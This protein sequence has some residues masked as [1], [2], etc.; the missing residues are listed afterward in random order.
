[1]SEVRGGRVDM[2]IHTGD[3]FDTAHPGAHAEAA[4]A[5]LAEAASLVPTVV[6][7]GNHDKRGLAPIL[8]AHPALV[9]V[10]HPRRM[11][12]GGLEL[13]CIPYQRFSETFATAARALEITTAD[14]VL[15][16]QTFHGHAVPGFMFRVG[17]HRDVVGPQHL[18]DREFV[19]LCGHIHTRQVVRTAG[20]TVVTPG[21]TE[22][23]A[24]AEASETKG[25]AL[26]E[27]GRGVQWRFVDT[28]TRPMVVAR[29]P[30]DL[31]RVEPG[32]LVRAEADLH[33]DV[34]QRG[35]WIA[36][37]KVGRPLPPGPRPRQLGLL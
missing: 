4:A 5:L 36:P 23:T 31:D 1:M 28:P 8:G 25:Y 11:R 10:D 33:E 24:F 12:V 15:C 32:A 3:V 16:H 35:G 30:R 13:A 6:L 2:V 34:R 22:R 21:S 19:A 37:G 9:L 14:L 18:P 26:I 17:S 7:A 29:G 27:V 20:A